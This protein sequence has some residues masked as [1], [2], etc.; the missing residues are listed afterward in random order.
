MGALPPGWTTVAIV[1]LGAAVAGFAEGAAEADFP[2]LALSLWAWT[3]PPPLAAALAVF[4]ALT[5]AVVGLFP[6]RGFDLRRFAPF[7]AGGALGVPLGVFLLHN[8]DP[9]RFRIAI[10]ALLALYAVFA[11][12][13]RNSARAKGIGIGADAFVGVIGG[14][15]GALSG[16]AAAAP[17]IWMRLGGWKR[18][19]RRSTAR[20]FVVVVAILALAA[21]AR[22]GAV[23]PDD[24]RLF[25]FVAPVALVASFVGARATRKGGAQSLGRAVQLLSLASGAALLIVALRSVRGH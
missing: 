23:A 13:V 24:M 10:G 22:T 14:A 18:E 8:A 6:L 9:L 25:A 1:V 15:I 5:G 12:A 17:S 16:L 20:A 4:G 19:P 3:L 2:L 11:L 7:A 21:Y